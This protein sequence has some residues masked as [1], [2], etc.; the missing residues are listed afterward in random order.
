MTDYLNPNA[1]AEENDNSLIVEE[2]TENLDLKK[3]A[4]NYNSFQTVLDSKIGIS[5]DGRLISP[6]KLDSTIMQ[7]DGDQAEFGMLSFN[8]CA[9]KVL[10]VLHP[11]DRP[12]TYVEKGPTIASVKERSSRITKRRLISSSSSR[13]SVIDFLFLNSSFRNHSCTYIRIPL[14]LCI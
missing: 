14:S 1:T 8:F 3:P 7:N 12:H 10:F 4:D 13:E 11:A 2:P 5:A 9:N 6:I